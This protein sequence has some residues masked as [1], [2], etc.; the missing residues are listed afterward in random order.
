M[1]LVKCFIGIAIYSER[2]TKVNI[3]HTYSIA[4]IEHLLNFYCKPSQ[5]LT[6][7]FKGEEETCLS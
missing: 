3:R 4:Y 1:D 7:V 5:G 6:D 2:Y